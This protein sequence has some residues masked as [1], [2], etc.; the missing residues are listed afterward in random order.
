MRLVLN[1]IGLPAA[2]AVTALVSACATTPPGAGPSGPGVS[3]ARAAGREGAGEAR[4][5]A[6]ADPEARAIPAARIVRDYQEDEK[7]ADA[8]Y[9][10]RRVILEGRVTNI[11]D[12]F[13]TQALM[14]R[15]SE[16]EPGLQCYLARAEDARKVKV[17]DTVTLQG[18]IRGGELGAFM[19][20]DDCALM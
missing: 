18:K 13:G 14:V 11:N 9:R 10:G 20:V 1:R 15:D 6:A 3:T 7:A 16:S 4:G 19:V 12:V 17:G 2:L 5:E 8:R